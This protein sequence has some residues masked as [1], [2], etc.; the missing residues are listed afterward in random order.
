[1]IPGRV[2]RRWRKEMRKQKQKNKTT[3][4]EEFKQKL[5]ESGLL[6]EITP[7]LPPDKYPKDRV[8]IPVKGNAVSDLIIRERR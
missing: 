1:M 8:P 2:L 3:L 5:L 4:E 7:L 6:T